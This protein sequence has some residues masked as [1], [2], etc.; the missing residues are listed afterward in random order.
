MSEKQYHKTNESTY[1]ITYHVIF[2][3]RFTSADVHGDL[4]LTLKQILQ[5]ICADYNYHIN[6]LQIMPDYI[7]IC[8]DVSATVAPCDVARTLKSSGAIELLTAFPELKQ[9]YAKRGVFWSRGY[10]VSTQEQLST[11]TIRDYVEEVTNHS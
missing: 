7:H 4:E 9:F 8:V 10:F 6:L 11:A 1:L 3:P 2:C 5:K